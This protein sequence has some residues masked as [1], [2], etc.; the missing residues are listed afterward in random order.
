MQPSKVVVPLRL[1]EVLSTELKFDRATGVK[2]CAVAR[3]YG[4][5][6]V[7]K[8]KVAYGHHVSLHGHHISLH[9]HHVSLHGHRV[10]LQA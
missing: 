3:V 7:T 1:P 8:V 5:P 4:T 9:G 6:F 2:I 10:S